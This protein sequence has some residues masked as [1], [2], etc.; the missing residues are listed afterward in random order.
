MHF[1][2]KNKYFVRLFVG[3]FFFNRNN[4]L[5]YC[6][7]KYI[8]DFFSDFYPV[9]KSKL[10]FNTKSHKYS[11]FKKN[12]KIFQIFYLLNKKKLFSIIAIFF[13]FSN[14]LFLKISKFQNFLN[15]LNFLIFWFKIFINNCINFLNFK[16]NLDF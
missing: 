15:C 11:K 10:K 3:I 16:Q 1:N 2:T 12:P 9:G 4:F 14:Y 8:D 6:Y 13:K 7:A 5:H